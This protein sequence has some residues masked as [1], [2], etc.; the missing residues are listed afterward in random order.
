MG[1]CFLYGNGGGTGLNFKVVGGTTRPSNPAENTIRVNTSEKLT[2][3]SFGSEAPENPVIGMVWLDIGTASPIAFNALKGNAIMI[4]PL[5][6]YQY[7]ATGW[8][9]M[10]AEIWQ[11][12]E[13]KNFLT[14]VIF[15]ANSEF[16]TA[17]FGEPTGITNAG[18]NVMHWVNGYGASATKLFQVD[19]FK[20][21]EIVV[22]SAKWGFID[23]ALVD[24][25]GVTA[26]YRRI[27][28]ETY[29][30]TFYVDISGM[31]G[32]YYLKMSCYA[33]ST[34]DWVNISDIKFVAE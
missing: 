10:S 18:G 12:G 3:W 1:K 25:N 16:N 22:P 15:Y 7:L 20:W 13:W 8:V 28:T 27:E 19:G 5:A 26:K 29:A 30:E 14:D 32:L 4:Y 11:A 33:A 34:S 23:V 21:I 24:E 17:V 9:R 6:A 2:G 31:S